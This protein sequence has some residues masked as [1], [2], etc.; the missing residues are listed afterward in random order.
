MSMKISDQKKNPLMKREEVWVSF[1]HTGKATPTRKDMLTEI[2]KALKSKEELVII[3]KIFTDKG[4]AESKAK[5]FV[6]KKKEDIP[7]DKLDKMQRRM[8]KKK[9]GAAATEEAPKAEAKPEEKKEEPKTE[10][11]AEK[12][13]AEATK[14]EAKE[15]PKEE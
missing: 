15:A 11:K 13:P 8:N 12:K 2:S 14:E 3:D 10:E 4:V 7:K 1:E 9:K 5:V 6:Y